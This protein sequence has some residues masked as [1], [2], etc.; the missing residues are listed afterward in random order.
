[1]T[2]FALARSVTNRRAAGAVYIF[3]KQRLVSLW[4]PYDVVGP[5]ARQSVKICVIRVICGLI[6]IRVRSC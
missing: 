5:A 3:Y 1:M 2:T 6:K 4:N